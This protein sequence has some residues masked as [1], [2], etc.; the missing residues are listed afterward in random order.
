MVNRPRAEVQD[1]GRETESRARREE[2]GLCDRDDEEQQLSSASPG[3]KNRAAGT[4]QDTAAAMSTTMAPLHA[5]AILASPL[6]VRTTFHSQHVQ[7][8]SDFSCPVPSGS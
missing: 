6:S 3:S 4:I 7:L 1:Q 2:G 8:T 5:H